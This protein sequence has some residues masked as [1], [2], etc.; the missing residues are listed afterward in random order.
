MSQTP[1]ETVPEYVEPTAPDPERELERP[2]YSDAG[3]GVPLEPTEPSDEE[4]AAN[5]AI[6]NAPVSE[7]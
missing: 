3:D 5:D 6:L 2:A 4:R 7:D 1:D